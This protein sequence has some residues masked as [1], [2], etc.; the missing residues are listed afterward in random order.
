MNFFGHAAVASWQSPDVGFVLGAMLPDFATMIR[1]RIPG[2]QHERLL[3]GIRFHHQT[4]DVFHDTS[5]FRALTRWAL[6]DLLERGMRRGSARAVAHVGVEILLDKSLAHD[7]GARRAYRQAL[8]KSAPH[9]LGSELD[10]QPAEAEARFER[11]RTTLESRGVAA[12]DASPELLA[13]RLER[14][15]AGRP[16]LALDPPAQRIARDWAEH[17]GER[18]SRSSATLL[19]ELRSGLGL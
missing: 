14:A 8:E 10:W 4:D 2:T 17:A 13:F 19:G 1:A 11:L 6:S 18:V 5:T 15:L 16:R 3:A 7:D 9:A 12:D